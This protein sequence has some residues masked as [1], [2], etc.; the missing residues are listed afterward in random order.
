MSPYLH[1]VSLMTPQGYNNVCVCVCDGW[2]VDVE[3]G[4][5]TGNIQLIDFF[6]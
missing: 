6:S 5:I 1:K 4:P 2:V 3:V